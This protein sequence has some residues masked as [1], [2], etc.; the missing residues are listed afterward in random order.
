[1]RKPGYNLALA[2]LLLCFI[3]VILG[4]YT[5]LVHAGLGCP[6][7]PGCYGFLTVPQSDHALETAQLR[8]PDDPVEAF[9]A[10]AEMIHRYAAGTLGLLILGLAVIGIR[11]RR[12]PGYPTGLCVGLL[13]LVVCQA[14][15]GMWT[16]TLKLWPQVVTAHLLGGFATLSLLLLLVLR[17][18][19]RLPALHPTRSLTRLRL[20]ARFAL[21]VVILQIML[22]GWTSTNYAAVA[23][24]DL[25]TCHG[26][27]WPEMDF[28]TGFNLLHQEIGPNYLGGMLE[29]PG[30]TAIH[31]TH[32]LGALITTFVV[33]LLGWQLW[34]ARLHGLALLLCLALTAQVGLGITNVLAALP[35]AVAVAHNGMA[36]LLLLCTLA[37]NYRVRAPAAVRV[38]LEARP[39][40]S[41]ASHA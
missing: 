23:C 4:A 13:A 8:F 17:L 19:G 37:V 12:D 30:R 26:E 22:G 29:G 25:P 32:R 2:G 33:L 14:L 15:F 27:W 38:R 10:W 41:L 5:R 39:R 40:R 3:V 28:H 31:F 18:S 24:I 21:A 9:K 36:A 16:V 1:M 34:R 11:Q 20:L 6:D 7:W 35:L